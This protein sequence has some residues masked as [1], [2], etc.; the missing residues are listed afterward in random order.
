[1][2]D[3]IF[4]NKEVNFCIYAGVANIDWE[5]RKRLAQTLCL[6]LFYKRNKIG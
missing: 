4:V 1:M 2:T 6:V 5:I 3:P